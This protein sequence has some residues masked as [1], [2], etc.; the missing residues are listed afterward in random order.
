MQQ[1]RIEE[2]IQE[3][4]IDDIL[5]EEAEKVCPTINFYINGDGKDTLSEYDLVSL[6]ILLLMAVKKPK[7]WSNGRLKNPINNTIRIGQLIPFTNT[8]VSN[9]QFNN[10]R[11][12]YSY[13]LQLLHVNAIALLD[14]NYIYQKAR[15]ISEDDKYNMTLI[16]VFNLLSFANIKA[17]HDHFI[18][19]CIVE[20]SLGN[21]PIVLLNYIPTPIEVLRL[22]AN[23]TRV[24]TMLTSYSELTSY[25]ISKL[26]YMDG[27]LE[28]SKNTLEFLIHD[29]K[30]MEHFYDQNIYF[31]QVG[32][33]SGMLN[34]GN[35]NPKSFFMKEL[36]YDKEL[37][38]V[39]E[40]VISDM[41]CYS[42]HLLRYLYAKIYAATERM[43]RKS[44]QLKLDESYQ[45]NNEEATVGSKVYPTISMDKMEIRRLMEEKWSHV[46]QMLS[47]DPN[48]NETNNIHQICMSLIAISHKERDDLDEN[49]AEQIRTFFR[50]KFI[51]K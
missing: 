35:G 44:I 14:L 47:M 37:W 30:H 12:N 36:G 18:N 32:F 45:S 11:S 49:E 46:L 3:K 2:E 16:D 20:W 8:S 13:R 51:I 29:I 15:I 26:S 41:N 24:V 19:K 25:H 43:Y 9:K 39:L 10:T 4:E 34:L 33:F 38:I 27:Q 22:Q 21:R 23:G 50:T 42:T 6:Y 17:N 28:H 48:N 40:Y 31:E 5:Y 7:K 1:V